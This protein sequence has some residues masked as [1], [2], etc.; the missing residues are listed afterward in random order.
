MECRKGDEEGLILVLDFWNLRRAALPGRSSPLGEGGRDGSG[1]F[2]TA[3]VTGVEGAGVTGNL[4][5]VGSMREKYTPI[6]LERV[7]SRLSHH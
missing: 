3:G 5:R 4:S 6:P 1:V 2:P 7:T